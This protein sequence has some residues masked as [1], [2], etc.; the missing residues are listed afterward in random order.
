MTMPGYIKIGAARIREQSGLF[1]DDLEPG[2][3]IEHRPGRTITASD[4][5]WQSLLAMNQ[6]PLHIDTEYAA[7]TEFGQILVSS[8]VT[9]SIVNGQTVSSVSQNAIANLGWD[10]VRLLAPVFV[11]DTLYAESTVMARRESKS[12][13]HQGIVTVHTVGRNQ[14]GV[15]VIEFDRTILTI[16]QAGNDMAKYPD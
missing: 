5:A 9:F 13:P 11:N 16:S 3:V 6:H 7:K 15:I 8:L 2:L 1:L 12:R 10:A 14:H 4:N